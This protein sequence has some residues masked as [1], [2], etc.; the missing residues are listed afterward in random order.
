[1]NGSTPPRP[2]NGSRSSA[3]ERASALAEAGQL[4]LPSSLS[5]ALRGMLQRARDE[6]L[7]IGHDTSALMAGSGVVPGNGG[8]GSTGPRGAV[9]LLGGSRP[10]GVE[11]AIQI[12]PK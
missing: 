1:M 6:R 9:G 4:S 10:S 5:T 8:A 11:L 2:N 12:A 7:R 3:A